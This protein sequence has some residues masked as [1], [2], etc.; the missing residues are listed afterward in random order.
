MLFNTSWCS[1]RKSNKELFAVTRNVDFYVITVCVGAD[2]VRGQL[3]ND[4]IE[5]LLEL[6]LHCRLIA[7]HLLILLLYTTHTHTHTHRLIKVK[8]TTDRK[9]TNWQI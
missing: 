8:L 6:A 1:E 5:V 7:A 9:Q 3:I 2:E 4:R